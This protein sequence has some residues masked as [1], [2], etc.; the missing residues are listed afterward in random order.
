MATRSN[1]KKR[2]LVAVVQ[3]NNGTRGS[4]SKKGAYR[5][6]IETRKFPPLF[7]CEEKSHSLIRAMDKR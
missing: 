5:S 2:P 1:L 4:S 3:K 6:K 7:S